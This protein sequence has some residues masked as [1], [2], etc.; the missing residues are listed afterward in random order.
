M[1][2]EPDHALSYTCSPRT[3]AKLQ[4]RNAKERQ[5]AQQTDRPPTLEP[6]WDGDDRNPRKEARRAVS[7]P[8]LPIDL[9]QEPSYVERIELNWNDKTPSFAGNI[10]HRKEKRRYGK[11][12]NEGHDAV[13]V[14]VFGLFS[15]SSTL[16]GRGFASGISTS[17]IAVLD[18]PIGNE[19]GREVLLFCSRLGDEEAASA[20]FSDCAFSACA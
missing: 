15:F 16:D 18:N 20:T 17:S 19:G 5:S 14:A 7:L 6:H 8:R 1:V 4:K 10:I 11:V 3:M 13:D 2:V 9:I 12:G